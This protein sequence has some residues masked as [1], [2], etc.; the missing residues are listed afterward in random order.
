MRADTSFAYEMTTILQQ[1]II[2][3]L[4]IHALISCKQN[5][6]IYSSVHRTTLLATILRNKRNKLQI[7]IILDSIHRPIPH[8]KRN[9]EIV[10]L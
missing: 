5:H 4:I 7:R 9:V 10:F 3:A 2:T 8:K 1:N 6:K